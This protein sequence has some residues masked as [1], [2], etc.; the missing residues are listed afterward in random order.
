MDKEKEYRK[1]FY[2]LKR[3]AKSPLTYT[4]TRGYSAGLADRE[5]A[6]II[7]DY[8][9]FLDGDTKIL[10]EEKLHLLYEFGEKVDL[11][12]SNR[13]LMGTGFYRNILSH[14]KREITNVEKGLP[15]QTR[16]K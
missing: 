12:E 9:L 16:R 3:W 11:E 8:I 15:V 7:Y 2:F 6:K 10:Y 5:P 14:I 13:P 1:V 4:Y